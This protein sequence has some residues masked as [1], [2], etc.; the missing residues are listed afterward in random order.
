MSTLEHTKK[1]LK[2]Q[3]VELSNL[4]RKNREELVV[5][6]ILEKLLKNVEKLSETKVTMKEERLL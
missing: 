3:Q 1:L 6:S 5:C 4:L 2:E